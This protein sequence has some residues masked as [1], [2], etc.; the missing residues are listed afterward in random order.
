MTPT[1]NSDPNSK[2]LRTE[3]VKLL[4]FEKSIEAACRNVVSGKPLDKA[5]VLA[6]LSALA[7]S[8]AAVSAKLGTDAPLRLVAEAKAAAAQPVESSS[9]LVNLAE[10]ASKSHALLET[11]A[12][13]GSF[14]ILQASGGTPKRATT[15]TVASLLMNGPF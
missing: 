14:Q 1:A 3:Q 9:W 2:D 10:A 7:A 4:R 11:L 15:E 13:D 12:Q 5:P 6:S 8:A